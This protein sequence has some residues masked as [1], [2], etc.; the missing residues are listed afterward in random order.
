MPLLIYAAEIAGRQSARAPA[1]SAGRAG[2]CH[3]PG[4][5]RSPTR[6]CGEITVWTRLCFSAALVLWAISSPSFG[7][8]PSTLK[9]QF[10]DAERR[11]VRL[12]PSAYPELP[13]GVAGELKRRGCRIPQET[14]TKKPHNVIE[15]EFSRAGQTDWAV[16]CSVKGVS[17]ILV[18]WNGSEK[19]PAQIAPLEDRIFLQGLGGDRIGYSRG[20]SAVGRDFIM[21]HYR[22]Y[23]GPKPPPI[24]H[25]GIDDAFIEKASVTWYFYRGKWLK[26]TGAD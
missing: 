6:I 26:L 7:Q 9:R 16:L 17:T 21:R 3:R 8:L 25:Q 1:A 18:F 4:A 24:D 5:P 19:N 2:A 15:G 23:G 10:D 12:A 20:I 14:F 11:I 13:A 22:A